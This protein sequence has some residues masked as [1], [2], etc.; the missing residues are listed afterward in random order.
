MAKK[1]ALFGAS[2]SIGKNTLK[3]IEQHKDKFLLL[4]FSI[5]KNLNFAKQIIKEYP[6]IKKF[7]ITDRETFKRA[8]EDSFFQ[9][10][11]ILF[12]KEGLIEISN[13][14]D[15]DIIVVATASIIGVFPTIEG[16]KNG[17]RVALANKE[18][19]VSFGPIVK[20][21]W[22]NS[23]G[24]IIPIDSEHSALF[25]LINSVKREEIDYIILT[26]SGGPFREYSKKQLE[27]VKIEDAL[28]HPTWK[29]GKKIT[30]DSAT[31]M[32]KSLEI[33]E[34]FW[35]F[36]FK[37][38][39]IKV[40]IHPQSIIHGMIVL[41]D[42]AILSHMSVPDMKIPILYALSYP[43]RL[44]ITLE[45]N[46][47]NI[48]NLEFFEPDFEKFPALKLGYYALE[49]GGS[50]PCVL[51]ASNEEAVYAFLEGKIKFTEITKIVEKVMNIH[52]PVKNPSFDDLLYFDKWAREKTKELISNV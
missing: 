30:I 34:A 29:M 3:V 28:K 24:E 37:P 49:I 7:V 42:G 45:K 50:M 13:E 4:T 19:L 15:I 18:T 20:N 44:K 27:N 48:P 14:P 36:D 35:L 8:K 25:Q 33:I 23:K 40:K 43:K 2:G 1:I 9:K 46:L 22:K 11:K 16:L 41:K 12:G 31:L 51:N 5:H 38:D 26:A 39:K 21:V 10:Y 32:N 47:Q 52:N 17:K 6:Q